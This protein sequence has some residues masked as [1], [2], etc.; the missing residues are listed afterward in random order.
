M[1]SSGK[2]RYVVA[3]SSYRK[4]RYVHT[5]TCGNEKSDLPQL[6]TA[7]GDVNLPQVAVNIGANCGKLTS[8]VAVS[9]FR[10][11]YRKLIVRG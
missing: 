10:N 8:L 2:L 4:L 9:H 3:V 7:T 11:T 6:L 5:A 1:V